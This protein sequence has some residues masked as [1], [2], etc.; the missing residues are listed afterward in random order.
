MFYSLLQNGELFGLCAVPRCDRVSQII[1]YP[2]ENMDVQSIC[3]VRGVPT[4]LGMKAS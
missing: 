4:E 3:Y 2:F 1:E